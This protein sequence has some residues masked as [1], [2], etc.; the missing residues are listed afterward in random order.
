LFWHEFR[1]AASRADCTAG[2]NNA[3]SAPMIAITTNSSTSVK[4]VGLPS[5][6]GRSRRRVS[7]KLAFA[8]R[9]DAATCGRRGD[10]AVTKSLM[11]RVRFNRRRVMYRH[12]VPSLALGPKLKRIPTQRGHASIVGSGRNSGNRIVQLI[13]GGRARSEKTFEWRP[14]QVR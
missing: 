11:S 13:D 10:L 1:R 2:S 9:R 12:P 5:R 4:P 14:L 3:T 8:S 7:P 6:G